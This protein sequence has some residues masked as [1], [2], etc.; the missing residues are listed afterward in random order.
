MNVAMQLISNDKT[1]K[2]ITIHDLKDFN[3]QS[4]FTDVEKG[5]QL[6][7]TMPSTQ[8]AFDFLGDAIMELS[9]EN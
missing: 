4:F 9:A 6:V 5:E 8:K 7:A 1:V 2:I 3:S